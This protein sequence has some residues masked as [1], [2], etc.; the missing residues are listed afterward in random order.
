MDGRPVADVEAFRRDIGATAPATSR[1]LHVKRGAA[2]LDV[3]V[4]PVVGL[5]ARPAAPQPL[6]TPAS[7]EPASAPRTRAIRENHIGYLIVLLL[8]GVLAILARVRRVQ[9]RVAVQAMMAL[10]MPLPV[11]LLADFLLRRRFAPSLGVELVTQLLATLTML[12]M[13]WLFWRR[14]KPHSQNRAHEPLDPPGA[15][16]HRDDTAGTSM[17]APLQASTA[18]AW[19]LLYIYAGGLRV[20][21]LIGLLNSVLHLPLNSAAEA[22]GVSS[23]WGGPG[24]L[25]FVLMGVVLAPLAEELLFRGLILPWLAS[26]MQ[27]TAALAWSAAVFG[28]GHLFYG[29]GAL[30]PVYYGLVLG[31]ARL[32]TGHLRAGMALHVL[33]NAVATL[34]AL[35]LQPVA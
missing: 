4:V 33:I 11:A 17:G 29:V 25:L 5:R 6:W 27:P 7:P 19:G 28:V 26:W 23:A 3:S 8:F 35:Y 34:A 21:A 12:L 15:M 32:R 18:F 14:R 9:V 1:T 24:I 10:A 16:S 20:A 2:E 31:W 30:L 13:A 22:F